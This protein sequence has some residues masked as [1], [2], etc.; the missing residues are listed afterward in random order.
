MQATLTFYLRAFEFT[1][2]NP[3]ID[4]NRYARLELCILSTNT[5]DV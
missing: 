5:A 3:P 4:A 1:E 2:T